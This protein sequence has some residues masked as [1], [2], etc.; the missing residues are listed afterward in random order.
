[1][2]QPD[3][4]FIDWKNEQQDHARVLWD[5]VC[6][7]ELPDLVGGHPNE[8]TEEEKKIFSKAPRGKAG[9]IIRQGHGRMCKCG[10]GKLH[11]D[12]AGHRWTDGKCNITRCK[13]NSFRRII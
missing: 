12:A 7:I 5:K 4:D 1:M 3:E 13:C 6:S 9:L 10:H 11:H 2:S 8:L